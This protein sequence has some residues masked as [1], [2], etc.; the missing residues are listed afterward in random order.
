MPAVMLMS[1][2]LA[3]AQ[4]KENQAREWVRK[5]VVEMG[6]EAALRNIKTARI[7]SLGHR[8]YLEQSERPDGPWIVGYDSRTEFCDYEHDALR[9]DETL[10]GL[11]AEEGFTTSF[12]VV[13]GVAQSNVGEKH[14]PGSLSQAIDAEEALNFTADRLVLHAFD[15]GDL[16]P[17]AD[18][19]IHGEPYHVVEFKQNGIPVRL[20]LNAFTGLPGVVEWTQSYPFSVFWR[21]WGDVR[22]RQEFTNYTLLPGGIR[23]PLQTDLSRDDQPYSSKIVTKL[24]LN[25]QLSS[26]TFAI[27]PEV[28]SAF[29]AM[30]KNPVE[31]PAMGKPRELVAGDDTLVQF[32]G[33]WNCALV[34]QPDGVVILEAPIGPVHTRQLLDEARRRYPNAPFKAVIT[35]TD[36]WPHFGGVREMVANGIPVYATDLNKPI[37]TRVVNAPFTLSPDTLAKSPKASKFHWVSAKTVIGT[38]A[39]RLEIYPIRN[40]SGERFLMVYL[41]QHKLL[42]VSDLAQPAGS[43]S[44]FMPEY[45]KELSEAASREHLAVDKFFAMHMPLTPWSDLLAAVEE[46]SAP[47]TVGA[48]GK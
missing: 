17:L 9:Q 24:E 29:E 21:V 10:R 43:G 4:Q 8:F 19:T 34:K 39:N 37:L 25:P 42:Y 40:A 48:S 3:F 15:A 6:G 32:V 35:T 47:A 18:A 11:G 33:A 45:L 44:F 23:L 12:T 27:A 16:K 7:E 14:V 2:V 28:K 41:P 36:A 22:N 46:A 5:A 1:C 30:K 31:T 38:G 26:E 20:Y 13:G